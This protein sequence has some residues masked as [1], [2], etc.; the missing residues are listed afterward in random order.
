MNKLHATALI[1]ANTTLDLYVGIADYAD[2][3]AVYTAS[4]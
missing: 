2:Q 4:Q 1:S 3:T